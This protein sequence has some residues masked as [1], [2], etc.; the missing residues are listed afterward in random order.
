MANRR[1]L[2]GQAVLL[3][4]SLPLIG[5][6]ALWGALAGAGLATLYTLL[7]IPAIGLMLLLTNIPAN[8]LQTMTCYSGASEAQM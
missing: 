4:A 5:Q 6:S 7:T 3:R 1:S 8:D 2:G